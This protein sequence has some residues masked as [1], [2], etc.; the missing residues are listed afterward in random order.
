MDTIKYV[1]RPYLFEVFIMLE[2]L[3]SPWT[4]EDFL[5]RENNQHERY[6]FVDGVV[7]VI[8]GGT[9]AQNTVYE[10]AYR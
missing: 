5:I 4:L 1:A 9:I 6:E 7:R 3:R 2:L 8:V 10:G